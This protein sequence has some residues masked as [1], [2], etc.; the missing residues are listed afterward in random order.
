MISHKESLINENGRSNLNDYILSPKIN[1]KQYRYKNNYYEKEEELK[2][3]M[4]II[5]R[6]KFKKYSLL[7]KYNL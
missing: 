6:D 4:K 7:S 1:R 5:Y 3:G 2:P